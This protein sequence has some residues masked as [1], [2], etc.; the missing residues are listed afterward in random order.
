MVEIPTKQIRITQLYAILAVLF[1]GF[2]IISNLVTVKFISLPWLSHLIIPCGLVFF[3]ITFFISSLVTE[4]FGESRARFIVYLGLSMCLVSLGVLVLALKFPA[5]PSWS[6]IHTQ[7][8]YSETSSYNHAFNTLFIFNSIALLS[9]MFAYAIAQL[10]DIRIFS[11]MKELTKGKKLWMRFCTSAV[12]SQII[13]T[14]VVNVLFLYCGLKLDLGIVIQISLACFLYKVLFIGA[15]V[16]LLY[17]AIDYSK[18]FIYGRKPKRTL[19]LSRLET[20]VETG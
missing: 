7:Y 5:H 9:S 8:G 15:T 20:N 11:F 4:L 12:T 18:L 10:L 1:S 6:I 2:L 17:L 14:L 16:P 19:L 13:D 3:P